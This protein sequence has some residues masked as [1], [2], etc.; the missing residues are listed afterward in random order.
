MASLD[1]S[2]VIPEAREELLIPAMKICLTNKALLLLIN[3]VQEGKGL[4][5]FRV[6]NREELL[7]QLQGDSIDYKSEIIVN[8]KKYFTILNEED[9]DKNKK[10]HSTIFRIGTKKL[11]DSFFNENDEYTYCYFLFA[12]LN[13]LGKKIIYSYI[14]K[15]N[16]LEKI[17]E[18]EKEV[19]TFLEN[20]IAQIRGDLKNILDKIK[21]Y[22][23]KQQKFSNEGEGK[24]TF[25]ILYNII[26]KEHA[27]KGGAPAQEG[28]IEPIGL[29]EES[30]GV[31]PAKS[32]GESEDWLG[33]R[34]S[35][36]ATN[37]GIE[38]VFDSPPRTRKYDG[39]YG[40]SPHHTEDDLTV[41]HKSITNLSPVRGQF[42]P[43]K[44]MPGYHSDEDVSMDPNDAD[45]D[46]S[47]E[48]SIKLR[49]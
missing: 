48:L 38:S 20:N 3:Q 22:K 8:P 4:T 47:D 33:L 43:V 45:N 19:N 31:S 23:T 10:G 30:P 39:Y 9:K 41:E 27:S 6:L 28:N 5:T 32:N 15:A 2:V 26:K 17:K 24:Q 18:K 11:W 46:M 49:F 14:S 16:N 12:C 35:N 44:G 29:Y 34:Y 25:D 37:K 13:L 40:D 42:D 36:E 21:D 7:I 1:S